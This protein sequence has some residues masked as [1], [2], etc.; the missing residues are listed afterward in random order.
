MPLSEAIDDEMK[1]EP[2]GGTGPGLQAAIDARARNRIARRRERPRAAFRSHRYAHRVARRCAGGHRSAN[3]SETPA[4]PNSTM[5]YTPVIPA[6]LIVRQ[7][8]KRATGPTEYP[9]AARPNPLFQS[10]YPTPCSKRADSLEAVDDR[11][12]T[13]SGSATDCDF[14][15][16]LSWVII[17]SSTGAGSINGSDGATA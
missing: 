10:R 14:P 5:I 12:V 8:T 16:R 17:A 7:P 15:S 1:S 13:G 6:E 11:A 4:E 3:P 2:S 9:A